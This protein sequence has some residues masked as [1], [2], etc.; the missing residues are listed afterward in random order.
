[1]KVS[2]KERRIIG[3][4]LDEW[5][6]QGVLTQEEHDK[7]TRT[8]EVSAFDWTQIARYSFTML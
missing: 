2:K 8:F 7:L 5:Q 3:K 6:S 1:M 4:A